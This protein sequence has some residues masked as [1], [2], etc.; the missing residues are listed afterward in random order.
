MTAI[1]SVPSFSLPAF[2]LRDEYDRSSHHRDV[3]AN[4]DTATEFR[5]KAA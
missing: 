1:P 4:C 3:N 5:L 2:V